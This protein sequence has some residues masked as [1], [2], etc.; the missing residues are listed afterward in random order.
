MPSTATR[1]SA[2]GHYPTALIDTRWAAGGRRLLLRPVLPQDESLLAALVLAQSPAA[3]RN[4]FHGAVRPS[5][6]LC[7]QMAQVDHHRHLAL[8]VSTVEHGQEQLL[9]DARYCVADDGRSAEFALL[10]D[11]RWQRHGVGAWA[12][13]ALQQ[14]AAG[15]GL[16]WLEGDVLQD[17]QAMLG[18]ARR[19]GFAC[20]PD[21]QDERLVRVQRRLAP[22]DAHPLPPAAPSLLRRL[23]R[24]LAGQPAGLH[25]ATPFRALQ[26]RPQP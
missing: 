23:L 16:A 17:N 7:R 12:L 11:E 18:L 19:C 10:V 25:F 2:P 15:A 1:D 3:R 26:T 20:A 4:R 13:R 24:T 9:A 8:V 5:A 21:P 22:A 6:G 14:A